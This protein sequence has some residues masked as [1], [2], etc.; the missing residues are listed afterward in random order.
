MR[1]VTGENLLCLLERRLDNVVY[2]LGIGA[3]RAQA[4]QIVLH[5]HITV[6]GKRVNIPSFSVKAGDK[7]A[8]HEGSRDIEH[9]KA[10]REGT[11]RTLPKW[12]TFDAENLT[13]SVDALPLREDVDLTINEQ[14][15]VEYYSR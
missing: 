11:G 5:G 8:V 9:F 6:N 2:R 7:V 12:L 14:L 15:I 3:S 4:R 1:G 13:G 10:L